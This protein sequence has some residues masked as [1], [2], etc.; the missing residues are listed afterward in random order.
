V[1]SSRANWNDDRLDDLSG[2]VS[3]LEMRMDARFNELESR[4]DA[5]F[6]A[7]NS[8]LHDM[9]RSMIVTLASILAAF[10]GLLA[11]IRF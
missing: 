4:L 7:I 2:R 10:G 8:T 6:E 3:H 11:A 5:R 1:E 9:Q